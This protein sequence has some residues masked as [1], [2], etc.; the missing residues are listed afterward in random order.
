[1][2]SLH[3]TTDRDGL[4]THGEGP[5]RASTTARIALVLSATALLL[6]GLV[7]IETLNE[8]GFRS[9]VDSRLACL[10]KQGANDC[11]VDGK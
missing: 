5:P 11:G 7:A 10:E 3:G 6:S 2:T 1:M 9:D 8:D 4:V